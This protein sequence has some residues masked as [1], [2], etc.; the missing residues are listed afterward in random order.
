M[1]KHPFVMLRRRNK[2]SIALVVLWVA[3]LAVTIGAMSA[4][5]GVSRTV[6]RPPIESWPTASRLARDR[7]SPTLIMFAHPRCE[8][9]KASL[10]ELRGLMSRVEG[11]VRAYVLFARS[12]EEPVESSRTDNVTLAESI[13]GI[14]VLGDEASREADRF[15][16]TTSGQVMLFDVGGHVLFSGGIAPVHGYPG[17][18]P[19][20]RGLLATIESTSSGG[21]MLA[22]VQMPNAVFGCALRGR[23]NDDDPRSPER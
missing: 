19:M 13:H 5:Q 16:A 8:C 15:G 11:K 18:S 10:T 9:T 12:K 4:C 23:G 20:L 21:P 17:D 7:T 3:G 2:I 14:T 6:A 22:R 1:R